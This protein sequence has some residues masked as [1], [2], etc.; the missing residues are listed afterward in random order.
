MSDAASVQQRCARRRRAGARI[1]R[2]ECSAGTSPLLPFHLPARLRLSSSVPARKKERGRK[3]KK[4]KN[5]N[6]LL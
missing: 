5:P 6:N 3:E 1:H 2:S 4:K